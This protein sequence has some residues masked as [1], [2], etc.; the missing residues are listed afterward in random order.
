MPGFCYA[1]SSQPENAEKYPVSLLRTYCVQHCQSLTIVSGSRKSALVLN[2]WYHGSNT[3]A[4]LQKHWPGF[5]ALM[6]ASNLL[7][8][9]TLDLLKH[10]R[11]RKL[12]SQIHRQ[13]H[14]LA[15]PDGRALC[16]PILMEI[17]Q[18][19]LGMIHTTLIARRGWC[20]MY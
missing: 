7:D 17:Q 9:W 12:I 14:T 10:P 2:S 20:S 8:V 4:F 11:S 6:M 19:G 16:L 15:Y 1:R 18:V 13:F 5:R 3:D